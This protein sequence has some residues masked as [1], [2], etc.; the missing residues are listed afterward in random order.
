MR[1]PNVMDLTP[2]LPSLTGFLY[3]RGTYIVWDTIPV[4]RPDSRSNVLMTVR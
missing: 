3:D 4:M 2:R 1:K